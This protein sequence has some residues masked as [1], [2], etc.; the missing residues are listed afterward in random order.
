MR[1]LFFEKRNFSHNIIFFL[2]ERG[3]IS[4]NFNKINKKI[5]NGYL[6]DGGRVKGGEG[7]GREGLFLFSF[8]GDGGGLLR[9]ERSLKEREVSL[10]NTKQRR[11]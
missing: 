9:G 6:E 3:S 2:M 10:S 1:K 11:P 7:M 8:W 5:Q 4:L